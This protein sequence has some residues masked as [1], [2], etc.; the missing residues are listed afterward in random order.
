MKEFYIVATPI[1]NLEDIT[2]RAIRIL[3]EVDIILCEDTRM[4]YRLLQHYNI[5]TKTESY[6]AHSTQG[7]EDAIISR[8][9]SGTRFA[10]VSDAGTPTIS[11]PGV[12]IVQRL[13]NDIVDI[14]IIPI[15]GPSA[16]VTA[17]SATGFTGNQFTFY[18]FLPHKKGRESMF[19]EMMTSPRVAIFYESPHRI[20]KTLDSLT[21]IA[22]TKRIAIARELTKIHEQIIIDSSENIYNYFIDNPDKVRGEFVVLIG[23]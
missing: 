6:N 8:V 11:D 10:L 5:K 19:T 22:G 9:M 7:K 17:L 1:G 23:K 2:Y 21:K 12:K 14:H 4:T 15:P 3:S 13:Y 16:L 18:G 20:M